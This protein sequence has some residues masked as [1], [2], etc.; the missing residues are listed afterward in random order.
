M[1]L[2]FDCLLKAILD[3]FKP[4]LILSILF[5]PTVT[6]IIWAILLL[7]YVGPLSQLV[8]QFFSDRLLPQ[9]I[10]RASDPITTFVF[11]ILSVSFV[12][13]GALALIYITNL[14][15]I[16]QLATPIV[17]RHLLKEN[18]KNLERRSG[19]SLQGS[20]L[21]VTKASALYVLAF[22][23]SSPLLLIPGVQL[24]VSATLT[25][26]LNRRVLIYD[27]LQDV[28]TDEERILLLKENDRSFWA[29]GYF[30][31]FM[32]FIPGMAFL[33]PILALLAFGHLSYD[34]L[35]AMRRLE[36]LPS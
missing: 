10:T 21:N 12:V 3:L 33:L 34:R 28:A 11:D 36:P 13:F 1:K 18:F 8:F 2:A 22:V 9:E 16:T 15:L 14:I 31:G 19:G 35:E 25:A 6:F 20:L 17:Q 27:L 26:W 29:L 23:A 32:I 30:L 4:R 7:L 24:L 5:I